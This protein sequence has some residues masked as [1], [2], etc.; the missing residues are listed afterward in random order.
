MNKLITLMSL[1][2]SV[3]V[4]A[5]SCEEQN[6]KLQVLG[7]GGPE[8]TDG[9]VSSSHLIWVNDQA[10]IL[11]DAGSGSAHQFEQAQAHS[12]HLQ[13]ILLTHLHVDHSVDVPAF[14]KDAYFTDRSKDLWVMGPAGNDMMPATSTYL[15]ELFSN[16]GAYRYLSD[17]WEPNKSSAFKIKAKDASLSHHQI[18]QHTLNDAIKLSSTG[19][20][21]GPISAVAWRVDIGDCAITFSGDM[22]NQFGSL[23]KLAKGTDLLVANNAIEE[24][25]TGT[26]RKLH[27]PPSE[28]AKIAAAAQP[29]K[30][31]L[32]HFMTRSLPHQKQAVELI[33]NSY[34]G[35]VVLA[36]DGL[37]ISLD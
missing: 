25:A 6:I 32:A 23:A 20:H 15:A 27:M 24:A 9:R 7:S 35:P 3:A 19:T 12:E 37:I 5:Q 1:L 28:I 8:L 17:Y 4:G 29:K 16:K 36:E 11:V 14:I 33:K 10:A 30:L 34:D 13:A 22:N 18:Q 2:W 31:L 26:A 21:H